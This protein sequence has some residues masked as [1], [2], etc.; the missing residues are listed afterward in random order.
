MK[1]IQNYVFLCVI[2]SLLISS[3]KSLP[4]SARKQD[5]VILN[6]K[7]TIYGTKVRG[8]KWFNAMGKV[9][10]TNNKGKNEIEKVYPYNEIYQI[11]YYDRKNRKSVVEIVEE[12]PKVENTHVEMD[13]VINQGKVKLYYH[14]P[15]QWAD[16]PFIVSDIYYGYAHKR[17]F[18]KFLK[19]LDK[20]AAFREKFTERK[21]R[22]KKN[23]KQLIQFYNENCE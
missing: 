11:H 9:K 6:T 10:V 2:M 21:E 5:F 7:D 19:E 4:V 15:G 3:C 23:I 14:D 22:R 20:C 1:A 12:Y 16:R 13:V 17:G 18:K 8:S